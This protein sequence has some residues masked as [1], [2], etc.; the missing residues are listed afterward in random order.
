MPVTC[1]NLTWRTGKQIY[2]CLSASVMDRCILLHQ[3]LVQE[4]SGQQT[5]VLKA[6]ASS[7]FKLLGAVD[8]T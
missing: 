8:N 7:L 3:L 6:A 5:A 4:G 2:N 1:H